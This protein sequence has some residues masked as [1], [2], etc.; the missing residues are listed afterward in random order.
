MVAAKAKKAVEDLDCSAER[1]LNQLT[2][3]AFFDK[4]TL[5][6]KD[7]SLLPIHKWPDAAAAAVASLETE[8]IPATQNR[9]RTVVRKVKVADQVRCLELLGKHRKLFTDLSESTVKVSLEE[10]VAGDDGSDE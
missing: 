2:R 3:I 1:I 4:R 6:A 8:E 9:N 5:Y 10:L 7:G